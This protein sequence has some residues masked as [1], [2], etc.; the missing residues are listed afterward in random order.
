MVAQRI[1]SQR[2]KA[3]RGFHK[4]VEYI[5]L[6]HNPCFTYIHSHMKSFITRPAVLNSILIILAV[7]AG[8]LGYLVYEKYAPL[9]L[10]LI[11]SQTGV[12]A[13]SLFDYA[14]MSD[15]ELVLALPNSSEA[16]PEIL[17][18]YSAEADMRAEET[19]QVVISAACAAEPM[20]AA[21]ALGDTVLFVNEDNRAHTLQLTPD[22]TVVIP[23]HSSKLVTIDFVTGKG[24]YG[25][26][27]D[28][29]MVLSG[30][31]VIR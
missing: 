5:I 15:Q 17:Q 28:N 31:L 3:R 21:V 2:S 30:M 19:D 18:V 7:T 11:P 23:D 29:Y 4:S 26:P 10:N 16:S 20:I 14:S 24:M 6:Y 12:V 9:N 22:V 8:V 13:E 27:C 25:Y 1:R